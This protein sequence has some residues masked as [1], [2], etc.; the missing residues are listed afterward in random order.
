MEE[1][2]RRT[3]SNWKT[4]LHVCPQTILFKQAQEQKSLVL[5]EFYLFIF[6]GG[7]YKLQGSRLQFISC[8]LAVQAAPHSWVNLRTGCVGPVGRNEEPVPISSFPC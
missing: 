7:R 3:T 4:L 6:F 1:K 8:L 5:S 2:N